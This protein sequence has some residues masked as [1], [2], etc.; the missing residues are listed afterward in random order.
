MT[1]IDIISQ[2]WSLRVIKNVRLQSLKFLRQTHSFIRLIRVIEA[3]RP[4]N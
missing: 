3:K 2:L 1:L 4:R